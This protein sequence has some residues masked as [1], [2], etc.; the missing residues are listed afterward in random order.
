M[1]FNNHMKRASSQSAACLPY[2]DSNFAG[3]MSINVITGKIFMRVLLRI[4]LRFQSR[5]RPALVPCP[6][7]KIFKKCLSI[8]DFI[9]F[10]YISDCECMQ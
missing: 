8:T 10:V 1:Y 3:I 5:S 6:I 7:L 9:L 2:V 4:I